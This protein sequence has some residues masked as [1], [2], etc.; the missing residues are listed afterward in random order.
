MCVLCVQRVWEENEAKT[1]E[2]EE[3]VQ[4]DEVTTISPK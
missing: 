1:G 3:T 4:Q 2:E